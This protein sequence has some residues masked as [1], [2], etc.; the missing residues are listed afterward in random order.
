MSG[1][2]ASSSGQSWFYEASGTPAGPATEAQLA[3]LLSRGIVSG[4]TRVWCPQLGKDWRP[5]SEIDALTPL[6]SG[7]ERAGSTTG[8]AVAAAPAAASGAS[9]P[10]AVATVAD[11]PAAW[12]YADAAGARVGPVPAAA[13]PSLVAAGL[14]TDASLVWRPGRDGWAAASTV[15]EFAGLF[16]DSAAVSAAA[17]AASRGADDDDPAR[18]LAAEAAAAVAAAAG[19]GAGSKRKRRAATKENPWVYI[20][21][22]SMEA[23]WLCGN[24]RAW[25]LQYPFPVAR[26][27]P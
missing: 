20:V 23:R 6:L 17:V 16:E 3:D 15:A 5:L 19:A 4:A 8:G 13:L 2:E 22:E 21:G 1:P 27:P 9:A 12:F 24:R 25:S 10:A 11:V 26:A 18:A 7:A 14:I